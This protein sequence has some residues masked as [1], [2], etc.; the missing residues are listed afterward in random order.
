M[1]IYWVTTYF[2]KA[3][4]GDQFK[5]W[6]MGAEA[7]QLL[8]QFRAETGLKYLGT[9]APILGFGD[10]DAEDWFEAPDW[11]ALD[12]LR[13]SKAGVQWTLKTWDFIDQTRPMRSRAM[14]TVQDVMI[15]APP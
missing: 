1:S 2:V 7:K 6:L 4:K 9:Y 8:E 3:E 13:D 5:Q 10:Y 12:K 11:A 14:R 15:T